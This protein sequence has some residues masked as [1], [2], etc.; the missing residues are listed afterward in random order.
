MID[1]NAVTKPLLGSQ[2]VSYVLGELDEQAVAEMDKRFQS[3]SRLRDELDSVRAHLGVHQRVRQVAPRRGSFERL[4]K[5]MKDDGTFQNAIPGCH[6]MLR[7]SFLAATLFGALAIFLLLAFSD[8]KRVAPQSDIIGEIVY[9]NNSGTVTQRRDVDR[10][11]QLMMNQLYD[12]GLKRAY[13]WLPTGVSNTYSIIDIGKDT[14]FEFLDTRKIELQRGFLRK[15]DINPGGISEDEFE[16]ITPH[17]RIRGNKCRLSVR[18]SPDNGQTDIAVADGSV[19]VYALDSDQSVALTNGHQTTV[20]AGKSPELPK[21]VLQLIL[22][23]VPGEPYLFDAK[24]VN[25][26]MFRFRIRKA[27]DPT[28]A[29]GDNIFIAYIAYANEYDPETGLPENGN[30]E[31]HGILLKGDIA[32]HSGEKW[33]DPGSAYT[34]RFDL[35]PDLGPSDPVEHWIRL[36]YRGDLFGPPGIARVK[37][38]SANLKVIPKKER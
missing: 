28:K 1:D 22:K 23:S 10:R 19:R 21:Q 18:I 5:R 4:R 7:R 33:L 8:G 11:D 35:S 20:R 29:F 26:G 34:F 16:I 6:C 32:L 9:Y 12:T 38:E 25:V 31:P 30:M 15:L 13:L 27:I 17:A 2:V 37:V 14:K 24:L 36:E 3:D